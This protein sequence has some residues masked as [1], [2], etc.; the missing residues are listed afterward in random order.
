MQGIPEPISARSTL[1]AKVSVSYVGARDCRNL[2]NLSVNAIPYNYLV[3]HRPNL[4][5]CRGAVRRVAR[6]KRTD[7]ALLALHAIAEVPLLHVKV[8]Y[9]AA[10]TGR[11][12]CEHCS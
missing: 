1:L 10:N 5:S 8:R 3:I 9:I 6:R 4:V 11:L 7:S 2:R 12:I